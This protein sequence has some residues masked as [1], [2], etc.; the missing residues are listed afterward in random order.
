MVFNDIDWEVRS[1]VGAKMFMSLKFW[2]SLD[3]VIIKKESTL[4]T[5]IVS[6]V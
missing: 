2:A 1:K 3:E 5:I 4:K 6:K